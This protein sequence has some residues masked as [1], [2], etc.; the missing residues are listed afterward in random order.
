MLFDI[1]TKI[2]ISSG[3]LSRVGELSSSYGDR[4]LL[5]T[6]KNFLQ[7]ENLIDTIIRSFSKN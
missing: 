5:V 7:S 6:G 3:L 2:E 1:P 4:V